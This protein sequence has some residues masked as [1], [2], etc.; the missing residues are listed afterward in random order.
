MH[1][2]RNLWLFLPAALSFLGCAAPGKVQ[3][4]PEQ[5][6]PTEKALL[7]K[8]SGNGLRRASYILGTIHMI[9]KNAFTLPE[10]V[11]KALD[12][13][14]RVAYE[15]DMKEVTNFRVQ[16]SLLAKANMRNGK[17]LKDLLKPEDYTFVHAKITES[18]MPAGMMER[19][20]PL[21]LST[22][23]STQEGDGPMQFGGGGNMTSVEMEVYK[24]AKKRGL[25][26]T[27]L[28][29]VD[30]QMSLFD[31]IPYAEQAKMLVENL[32]SSEGGADGN[33]E[34][35]AMI[36]TY[37]EKDIA[38]MQ[39]MSI[40]EQGASASFEEVLLTKRNRNWI[41]AM[42]RLML[43]RATFFAVGAG[44]LGGENGVIALL[45]KEGYRVVPVD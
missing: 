18:G 24:A 23:L 20:K 4:T 45:R 12:Q 39:R 36:K 25:S 11:E 16:F 7:W 31:T 19:L 28:E 21:F 33:D 32:R 3:Y 27:G 38:A 2:M 13:T 42:G 6:V 1:S 34:F 40:S 26:S 29:T 41:P 15:I 22:I 30:Y 14:K 9:P 37:Q 10:S 17:T 35:A 44:H 8:I 43:D 5:L